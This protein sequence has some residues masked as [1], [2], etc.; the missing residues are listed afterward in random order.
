[1]ARLKTDMLVSAALR[2]ADRHAIS[3]A[4]MHRGDPDAG[5]LF[6]EIEKSLHEAKLLCR[7]TSFDGGYEW[8]EIG[9][10]GWQLPMDVQELIEKERARDPDCWVVSVQDAQARNIFSFLADET[11]D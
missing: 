6:L 4:I 1:M 7:V 9:E 11:N 2:W 8:L 5:A 10:D 3:A